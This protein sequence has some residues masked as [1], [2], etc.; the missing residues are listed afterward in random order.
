MR[1]LEANCRKRD[2]RRQMKNAKDARGAEKGFRLNLAG[3]SGSA[4]FLI[5]NGGF[6]EFAQEHRGVTARRQGERKT[7]AVGFH[8]S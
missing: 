3:A 8:G 7:A 5:G 1:S 6:H 4:E 2:R